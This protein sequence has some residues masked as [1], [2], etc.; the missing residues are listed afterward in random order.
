MFMSGSTLP[1]HIIIRY[2]KIAIAQDPTQPLLHFHAAVQYWRMNNNPLAEHHA[3]QVRKLANGRDWEQI[4]WLDK[5]RNA[6]ITIRSKRNPK[7][8]TK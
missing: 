3:A 5:M 2:L 4:E 6:I 1:P 8:G 7:A